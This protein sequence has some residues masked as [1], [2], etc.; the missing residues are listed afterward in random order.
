MQASGWSCQLCETPI[1]RTKQRWN[2]RGD[3]SQVVVRIE[4]E[5]MICHRILR[6]SLIVYL[7]WINAGRGMG[8]VS[9]LFLNALLD[10][11]VN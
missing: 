1:G 8:L 6:S 9:P 5:E 7:S 10:V 4:F 11:D 2:F 3:E